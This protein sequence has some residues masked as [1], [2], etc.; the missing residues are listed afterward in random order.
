MPYRSF[1]ISVMI[2]TSPQRTIRGSNPN[3]YPLLALSL[4]LQITEQY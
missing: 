2:I 3:G 4:C 1:S